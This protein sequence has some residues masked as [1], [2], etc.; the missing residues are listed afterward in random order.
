MVRASWW[1]CGLLCSVV[2]AQDA[3]LGP[4]HVVRDSQS[5]AAAARSPWTDA[6][7]RIRCMG[8][9]AEQALRLLAG[10]LRV[11]VWMSPQLRSRLSETRVT[12][13]AECLTA[14]QAFYWLAQL[15]GG[16]AVTCQEGVYLC[17]VSPEAVAWAMWCRSGPQCQTG[18]TV[19]GALAKQ[20]A[21]NLHD[22]TVAASVEVIC[23]E[24]GVAGGC[25][26]GA[27]A[28]QDLVTLQSSEVSLAE[29]FSALCEQTGLAVRC[30]KGVYVL[31]RPREL[32]SP[33]W[34]GGERQAPAGAGPGL[35]TQADQA[36]P[37]E[38]ELEQAA[39]GGPCSDL[40]EALHLLEQASGPRPAAGGEPAKDS[41][42]R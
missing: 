27:R 24:F 12:L 39:G 8:E 23:G 29:A 36:A 25:L 1:S 26:P 11:P 9:P 31:G 6:R 42:N 2:L 30:L 16:Q 40:E 38:G 35:G 10:Q 21:I 14:E 22:A 37:P 5:L 34:R 17:P 19:P 7:V 20:A 13:H 15:S 4:I 28:C 41:I 33:P 32:E 18:Q 3:S